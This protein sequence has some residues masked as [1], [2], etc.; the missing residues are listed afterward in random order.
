[1]DSHIQSHGCWQSGSSTPA[2]AAD[3]IVSV[4]QRVREPV[5]LVQDPHAGSI[6]IAVGGETVH[7]E[8]TNGVPHWPLLAVLPPL[9]P[10]WLGCRS[11][12]EVHD[13]RFPY[14]SG[15]MA[16]GIATTQIV[17]EMAK[18]GFLGFFGAA[19]LPRHQVEAAVDEL[20]HVLGDSL[21][22]G[23]NL[24][25]SPNEPALEESVA[26]LYIRRGVKRVSAAAYM[27]LTLPSSDSLSAVF[28]KTPRDGF[29]EKDM[30]SPRSRDRRWQGGFSN[31]PPTP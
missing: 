7:Q 11:F 3:D 28:G 26:D 18:A 30:S 29:I 16:N 15:A 24:I 8:Q 2:F 9:Y 14:V 21:P 10:E 12:G 27:A 22:W 23:C 25:H 6:G 17:I 4:T 1:M 13:V 19:G 20:Q 31:Q 5:F